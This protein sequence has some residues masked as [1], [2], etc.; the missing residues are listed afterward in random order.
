MSNQRPT[1]QQV[2]EDW[3]VLDGTEFAV[4]PSV[5]IVTNIHDL[6]VDELQAE[7]VKPNRFVRL[8]RKCSLLFRFLHMMQI[9][10]T[11]DKNSVA[12]IDGSGIGWLFAGYIN[13]FLVRRRRIMIL[14]DC[15]LEYHLGKER[16]LWFFPFVKF[17]T[18]WKIALAR[19]AL[20]GYDT[21]TLW[22]RKQI[23]P[24]AKM[25]NLPEEQF[26][27]I[28]FKSNHSK[29]WRQR[30]HHLREMVGAEDSLSGSVQRHVDIGRGGGG[31]NKGG[32]PP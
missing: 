27:F 20:L 16:R 13:R 25:F 9:I 23:A 19:G 10:L 15:F 21:I 28:P 22:S 12:V 3:K 17:K 31:Q 24:H 5:R 4:S 6:A 14:S 29:R 11:A 32:F 2:Q 30:R 26:C 1:F 7:V 18:A 8:F